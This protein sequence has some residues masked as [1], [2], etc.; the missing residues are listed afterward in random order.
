MRALQEIGCFDLFRVRNAPV[1]HFLG[2]EAFEEL[3]CVEAAIRTDL[4]A[5]EIVGSPA[6]T[7]TTVTFSSSSSLVSVGRSAGR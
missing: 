7:V 5:V 6:T 2:F 1:E 4:W 3:W